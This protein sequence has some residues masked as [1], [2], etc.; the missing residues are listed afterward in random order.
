VST[1]KQ[2]LEALQEKLKS[3]EEE[4]KETPAMEDQ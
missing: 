4:A 3:K 2:R 1:L